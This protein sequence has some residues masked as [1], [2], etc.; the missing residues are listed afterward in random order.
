MW[1]RELIYREIICKVLIFNRLL[2]IN[3]KDF[4]VY[5]MC[6]FEFIGEEMSFLRLNFRTCG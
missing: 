1:N 4:C 3:I 2:V 6:V 5:F